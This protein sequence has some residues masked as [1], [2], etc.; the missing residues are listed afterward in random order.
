ME[1]YD[2]DVADEVLPCGLTE[3]QYYEFMCRELTPEDYDLLVLLDEQVAKP[4]ASDAAV[5]SLPAVDSEDFFGEAC[6][7][8]LLPFDKDDSV[9]KLPCGHVFHRA[10]V[11]KWLT[12]QRRACPL[13]GH[14]LS[15]K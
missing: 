3:S 9:A 11:A 6:T 14:E 5:Q 12:E 15:A 1:S 4:T 2:S 10:C 7:V 8:C 13:C